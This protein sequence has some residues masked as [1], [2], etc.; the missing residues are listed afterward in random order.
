MWLKIKHYQ[1]ELRTL[2]YVAHSDYC[3][4]LQKLLVE[5]GQTWLMMS[6][7]HSFDDLFYSYDSRSLTRNPTRIEAS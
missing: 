3:H 2:R 4:S 5:T 6:P 7:G 1:I